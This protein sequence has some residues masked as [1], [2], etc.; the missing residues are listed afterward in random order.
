MNNREKIIKDFESEIMNFTPACTSDE[1]LKEIME[2]ALELLK[3][4]GCENCAMDVE[5][6]QM[7]VRCKDCRWWVPGHITDKDDFIPPKCGK[8]QQMVGHSNSDYCSLAEREESEKN[9]GVAGVIGPRT[10]SERR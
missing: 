6:R 4:D 9:S 10:N 3:Q 5:D 8:Y 2:T 7:V 1:L